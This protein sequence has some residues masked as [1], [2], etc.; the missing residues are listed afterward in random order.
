MIS[1][2]PPFRD[3][4][5]LWASKRNWT[6]SQTGR[7]NQI[8]SQ[9]ANWEGLVVDAV[10]PSPDVTAALAQQYIGGKT[11]VS[12]AIPGDYLNAVEK[13][14][15][16]PDFKA[17]QKWTREALKLMADKHCL[18]I[19]LLCRIESAAGQKYLHNHGFNGTPNTAWWTP[20]EAW[21]EK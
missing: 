8:S 15:T 9:G 2:S 1:S 7:Y 17:K 16:A 18:Q 19:M 3:S 4:S 21:L 11:F 5:K 13:A 12:M 6:P 20:E 14:I 10:K